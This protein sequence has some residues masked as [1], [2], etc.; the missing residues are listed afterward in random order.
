MHVYLS[1]YLS[2]VALDGMDNQMVFKP[3]L[4]HIMLEQMMD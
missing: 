3:T 4:G 2:L 1:V